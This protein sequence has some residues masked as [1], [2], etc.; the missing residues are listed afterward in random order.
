MSTIRIFV[1]SFLLLFTAGSL[2]NEVRAQS[3]SSLSYQDFYDDLS[4]YG[5]WLYDDQYGYVWLP[6]VGPDFR[7]YYTNGYWAYTEYGNTWISNYDWGWA[8]FHYGRWTY[9][10]YYGW[11]WIPGNEWAPAWVSWRSSNNYYGWAPMGPG[12][13]IN[14]NLNL[15]PMDWWMFVSPNY[16]Y[17]RRFH[18]YC[19]NDWS[20]RRNIYRR[21]TVINYTYID[22]RTTYYFG[23]RGDDYYRRTG[24]RPSMFQIS[25]TTR[26]GNARVAA[27]N[28]IN[29]YRPDVRPAPQ[30]RPAQPMRVE[31]N[32]SRRPESFG[33]SMESAQG[34]MQILRQSPRYRDNDPNLRR[35]DLR[36]EPR[37]DFRNESPANPGRDRMNERS[38]EEPNRFNRENRQFAP[39]Q[40]APQ[41]QPRRDIRDIPVERYNRESERRTPIQQ[42]TDQQRILRE[43]QMEQQRRQQDMQQRIQQQ[44]DQ[45]RVMREQQMEQQRRQ[46]D[47]QQRM[48]QQADQQRIIR[49]QQMEQQRRQ[50]EMQQR[51]I[52]EQQTQ[53]MRLR[54]VPQRMQQNVEQQRPREMQPQQE[55][56]RFERS[57]P[58]SGE[59]QREEGMRGFRR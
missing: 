31:R 7:P 22:N 42:P 19:N 53:Q 2:K 46:Q 51:N 15:I 28:R 8:A 3:Y 58:Q 56:P 48:Q 24:M 47:M 4:P 57:A 18:S 49:E 25:A 50:Q 1:L 10:G 35:P 38:I 27:G 55:K 45:Q 6:D 26:R 32:I 12:I 30:A 52:R 43:Q 13:S 59:H 41:E 17:D 9:D 23:P 14:I 54:E 21:T 16:M 33:G 37:N 39:N 5:E 20:F 11:L 34:R 29:V 44:A 36:N 40:Q